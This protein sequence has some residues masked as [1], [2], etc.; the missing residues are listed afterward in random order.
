MRWNL[1]KCSHGCKGL[2][3]S[4]RAVTALPEYLG[5]KSA[6]TSLVKTIMEVSVG[7]SVLLPSLKF[8]QDTGICVLECN[9]FRMEL[10]AGWAWSCAPN[11]HPWIS[12]TCV[13]IS[14]Y[15]SVRL[16]LPLVSYLT[17]TLEIPW[18]WHPLFVLGLHSLLLNEPCG[19]TAK[20]QL[21]RVKDRQA[22]QST[23]L[24]V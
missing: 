21:L 18:G 20:Q 13:L 15:S 23:G 14:S 1:L 24:A 8:C 19:N 22:N 11:L 2:W 17:L 7:C 6:M 5:R 3:E 16:Y 4:S 12:H 10:V 9:T